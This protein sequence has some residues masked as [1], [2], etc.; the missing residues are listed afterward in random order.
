[1]LSTSIGEYRVPFSIEIR[2]RRCGL[3]KESSRNVWR[4]LLL[5]AKEDFREAYQLFVEKS[6]PQLLKGREKLLRY[7][8][9]MVKMLLL[10]RIWKNF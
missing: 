4:S 9:A 8:E 3:L 10:I 1:M 2:K 7:Y 5:L 6:F